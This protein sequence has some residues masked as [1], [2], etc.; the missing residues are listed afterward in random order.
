[1]EFQAHADPAVPEVANHVYA[2]PV[3]IGRAGASAAATVRTVGS[4]YMGVGVGCAWIFSVVFFAMTMNSVFGAR[5]HVYDN[6]GDAQAWADE[7][8]AVAAVTYDTL[9][10]SF[11]AQGIAAQLLFLLPGHGGFVPPA[12]VMPSAA[13]VAIQTASL[14]PTI[15][16]N[17]IE[18]SGVK[19][20]FDMVSDLDWRIR[21]SA[22]AALPEW[23]TALLMM[24]N[25]TYMDRRSNATQTFQLL[26][27]PRSSSSPGQ[28]FSQGCRIV[29]VSNS[30]GA[31][32]V[33]LSPVDEAYSCDY[34][35]TASGDE[36][37][38]PTD[39][40]VT[41]SVVVRPL[42]GAY[43]SIQ[44]LFKGPGPVY[45]S[46]NGSS[47]GSYSSA[48]IFV[49]FVATLA[50]VIG[51]CAL[52]SMYMKQRRIGWGPAHPDQYTTIR[53]DNDVEMNQQS[54]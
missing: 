12:G 33:S 52:T 46:S 28:L 23:Q 13:D 18:G 48:S 32:A 50:C 36:F 30:S 25:V 21:L 10:G 6:C 43:E 31:A 45:G 20:A 54:Y 42:Q 53:P 1:M 37:A 14:A 11:E 4:S 16:V 2:I 47:D 29:N 3:A 7:A 22:P 8:V 9:I 40:N 39:A 49:G 24:L 17:G 26:L 35:F 41:I 19:C 51:A 44:N 15:T 27:P 5:S 38:L 34:P